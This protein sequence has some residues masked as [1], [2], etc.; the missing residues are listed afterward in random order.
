MSSNHDIMANKAGRA[1]V[2]K[3]V[4]REDGKSEAS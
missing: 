4:S 2:S 3:I 1:I